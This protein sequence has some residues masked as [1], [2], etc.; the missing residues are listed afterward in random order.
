LVSHEQFAVIVNV[1]LRMLRLWR[2]FVGFF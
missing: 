2:R 1:N